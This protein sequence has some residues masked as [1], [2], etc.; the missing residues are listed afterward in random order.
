M[1]TR[2]RKNRQR[3]RTLKNKKKKSLKKKY[4]GGSNLL[5]AA[6]G[7]VGAAG[8]ASAAGL[9]P[10]AVVDNT[11]EKVISPFKKG[12]M[13]VKT[14]AEE[15]R[16]GIGSSIS[17]IK[18]VIRSNYNLMREKIKDNTG[19]GNDVNKIENI[20][21]GYRKQTYNLADF[22]NKISGFRDRLKHC[23]Y[24]TSNKNNYPFLFT[25]LNLLGTHDKTKAGL[26]Y[27]LNESKL[28]KNEI[29]NIINND[30]TNCIH[31]CSLKGLLNPLKEILSDKY[32]DEE[33]IEHSLNIWNK[34]KLNPLHYALKCKS[35]LGPDILRFLIEHD[36]NEN[37]KNMETN[38]DESSKLYT[39]F[40]LRQKNKKYSLAF[41]MMKILINENFKFPLGKDFIETN[42]VRIL[43]DMKNY[44]EEQ[45][46]KYIQQLS[47]LNDLSVNFYQCPDQS[48]GLL[49]DN[50]NNDFQDEDDYNDDFIDS[51][52]DS[53]NE[54]GNSVA[55]I[56][57]NVTVFENYDDILN[58]EDKIDNYDKFDVNTTKI[59]S[60][61]TVE[62]LED[63]GQFI[64]IKFGPTRGWIRK[65]DLSSPL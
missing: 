42:N 59:K 57:K 32:L 27:I 39:S 36:N 60:G 15:I 54:E 58:N 6:A 26:Q 40:L 35:K 18:D 49:E 11:V 8:V 19:I 47:H 56:N 38:F 46:L 30:D 14:S 50:Y 20:C 25:I 2:K 28:D 10:G 44:I 12:I 53:I 24:Y 16:Q 55:K 61:N 9:K 21:D 37:Y 51:D 34:K 62:I 64:K 13:D 41:D 5:G 1:M 63:K 17:A 52:S 65:V 29:L 43:N 45:E 33:N 23:F 48:N 31:Y 7:I 4:S 22:R 3:L